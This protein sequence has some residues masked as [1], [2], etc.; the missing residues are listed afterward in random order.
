MTS[1]VCQLINLL[2]NL[3]FAMNSD[4]ENE[5]QGFASSRESLFSSTLSNIQVIKNSIYHQN[6]H[7]YNHL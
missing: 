5:S 7:Y 4:D 2:S 6:I 3:L 1:I